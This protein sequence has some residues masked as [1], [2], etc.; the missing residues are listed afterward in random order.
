MRTP[1]PVGHE[2][3][4]SRAALHSRE[5]LS[6]REV[7]CREIVELFYGLFAE[8][9]AHFDSAAAQVG[10]SPAQ[11]RVLRLLPEPVPMSE[12]ATALKCDASYVTGI[13]DRL[14]GLGLVE[15]RPHPTDRRVRSLHLTP[16]G[17]VV[18]DQLDRLVVEDVPGTA[19]L[20]EQE[21]CTVRDA[22]A[23]LRTPSPTAPA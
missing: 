22:L 20:T 9:R 16:R 7:L 12:I 18:L 21:L 5:T 13:A 1:R 10:L 2:A 17:L 3:P 23:L 6:S 11:A 8:H 19:H 4:D 14:T 15:R